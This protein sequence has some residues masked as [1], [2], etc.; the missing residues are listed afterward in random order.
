[1]TPQTAKR[2]RRHGAKREDILES[3]ARLFMEQGY[4]ATSVREIGE[5]LDISQSSL[6]YHA[7]NKPQIL[8]D[9]N[10]EF[11]DELVAAMEEIA[12]RRATPIEKLGAI[13]HQLVQA[14][15]EHQAVVTVVLHERRSLPSAAA[16]RIQRK[17]DR[18]DEII[19]QVIRAGQEEGSL[20]ELD[21][22]IVRLALTGMCNWSYTWYRTG[23]GLS[24][25]DIA[26]A[27]LDLFVNGIGTRKR[28]AGA[29]DTS[30]QRAERS[31]RPD[32][33]R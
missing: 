10:Q 3:A 20:R 5:Y 32:G 14:V 9:L 13:I 1:M 21:P 28:S 26:E 33:A 31:S 29:R 25:N 7:K 24:A 23:G 8:V 16:A 11:M 22:H 4:H 17:R 27:F 18:V 12:A 19:D 2:P 30:R 15:A 6:Y